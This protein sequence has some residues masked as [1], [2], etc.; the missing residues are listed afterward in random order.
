M[1]RPLDKD[2]LV[3]LCRILMSACM[4]RYGAAKLIDIDLFV[5][6]VTT[7]RFMELVAGGAPAPLWFAYAN[8]IFQT[9]AGMCVL[10]GFQVRVA[11]GLLV[12]W[13]AVLTLVGHPFWRLSGGDALL[14]E[15]LFYRNLGLMA[16]FLLIVAHGA[17]RW[18][19]DAIDRK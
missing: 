1:T 15:S 17:G 13:L 9:A 14:N 16:A 19:V 8:A 7:R 12:V 10:I 5:D 18:A 4:I 2:L 3:L 11:A 6:H